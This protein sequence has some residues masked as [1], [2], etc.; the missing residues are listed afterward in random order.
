[1]MASHSSSL[2]ACNLKGIVKAIVDDFYEWACYKMLPQ[3]I[4]VTQSKR[5][6]SHG[7][8]RHRTNVI[9]C[10]EWAL[11]RKKFLKENNYSL[12]YS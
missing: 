12:N 10:P 7:A 2:Q 4:K 9:G 5:N 1:M 8:Q 3:I 11:R 6:L